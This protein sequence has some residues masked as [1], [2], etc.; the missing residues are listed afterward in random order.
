MIFQVSIIIEKNQRRPGEYL[1]Y[2]PFPSWY[3]GSNIWKAQATLDLLSTFN[4]YL[5]FL[6]FQI[7]WKVG[8]FKVNI[9]EFH[10]IIE[11]H[12]G[13]REIPIY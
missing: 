5:V 9:V 4:D 13:M 2:D 1:A 10:A 6:K 7:N 11:W 12:F 3:F 8:I